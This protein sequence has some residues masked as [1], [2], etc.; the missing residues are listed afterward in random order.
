MKS[1][2][3][4]S[5]VYSGELTVKLK[6]GNNLMLYTMKNAGHKPLW[7]TMAKAFAGYNVT[8]ELPRYIEV[9]LQNEGLNSATVAPVPFTGVV[10][11]D[12]VEKSETSTSVLYTAIITAADKLRSSDSYGYQ[13]HMLN[14]HGQILASIQHESLKGVWDAISPGID[15]VFEWKLIFS[16]QGEIH[17]G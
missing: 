13:L 14:S 2:I 5:I 9:V 11:G 4:N 10:Y 7:D 1:Q 16:N 3:T 12:V 8:A 6:S 15:A 17:N